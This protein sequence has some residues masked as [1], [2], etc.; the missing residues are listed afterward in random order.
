MKKETIVFSLGGS[1]IVPKEIDVKFLSRFRD[2]IIQILPRYKQVILVTGGG[3]ICRVYQKAAS[4]VIKVSNNDLDW[5]GIAATRYNAELVRAI[6]SG[7]A[8]PEVI[9]DPTK[10]VKTN[11]KLLIGCGWKPG[12]T[13]DKDAVLI[14]QTYNASSVVNLSNI[15]Y[16]YD[17]DPKKFHHAQPIT[18]MNWKEF[19]QVIGESFRPGMNAPFDPMAAKLAR[20][21]KLKVVIMKGTNLGNLKKFL[22]G[23]EF[24][25]TEIS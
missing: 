20:R 1:I 25:G 4:Q 21:L 12:C 5:I 17:K 14:A 10:K 16:V 8:Y 2:L 13:S 9:E 22:D 23:K 24:E 11:K 7:H 15:S 18:K 3:H 6:F 19:F